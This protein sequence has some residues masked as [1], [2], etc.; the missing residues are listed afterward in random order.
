QNRV[1]GQLVCQGLP[2]PRGA[3]AWTELGLA[4]I[5]QFA[6]PLADCPPAELWRGELHLLLER[7][8]SLEAQ[9]REVEA[10]LDTLAS[11]DGRVSPLPTAP[12]VGPRTAQA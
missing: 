1:R 5:G 7:L 6:R 12:G 2:A 3:R 8:C 9:T 11:R 4:G 10:R